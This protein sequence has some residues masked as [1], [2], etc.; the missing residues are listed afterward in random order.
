MQWREIKPGRGIGSL[1]VENEVP[2]RVP[3]ERQEQKRGSVCQESQQGFTPERLAG[4][5]ENA[6]G[7]V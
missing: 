4:Q 2:N 6:M 7:R 3:E 1:G 5:D